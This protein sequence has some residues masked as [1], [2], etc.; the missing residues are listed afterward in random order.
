[1]R[2]KMLS[3]YANAHRNV[4]RGKVVDLEDEEAGELIKHGF[5]SEV[6]P[7]KEAQAIEDKKQDV[8]RNSRVQEIAKEEEKKSLAKVSEKAAAKAKG[9]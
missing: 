1:M 2:V 9:A 7:N 5:A 8:K 6:K 4:I 3:N